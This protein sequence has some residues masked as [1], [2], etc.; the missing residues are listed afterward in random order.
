MAPT[1]DNFSSRIIEVLKQR[2]AFICSNPS[3]KKMTIA[4]S[5]LA[6]DKVVYIGRAAHIC[7]ASPGGPR[8]NTSLTF[9][10]RSDIT[11]AIFLC[12]NCADIVDDNNGDDYTVETLKEWKRDHETWVKSNLN[13]TASTGITDAI[14]EQFQQMRDEIIG[15]DSFGTLYPMSVRNGDDD[16]YFLYFENK[17]KYPM[18]D[19]SI[20]LWDPDA[21]KKENRPDRRL[22]VEDLKYY[23]TFDIG[24]ITSGGG[25]SFGESFSL[26]EQEYFKRNFN[27]NAKNGNF[28]GMLRI[29]KLNDKIVTAIRINTITNGTIPYKILLEEISPEMPRDDKGDFVW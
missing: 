24:N 18:S 8:Y 4:P 1:R 3:C 26:T 16:C 15:G 5:D 25:K 11:N 23:Q 19:I 21:L 6:D 14:K 12:A 10:Q 20:R 22:R 2:A 27:I 17:G 7:A 28:S 9:E 29:L 13:Q